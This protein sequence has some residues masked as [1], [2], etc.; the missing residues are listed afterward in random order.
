MAE[1]SIRLMKRGDAPRKKPYTPSSLKTRRVAPAT[2]LYLAGAPSVDFWLSCI[3]VLTTSCG[4]VSNVAKPPPK[5]PLAKLTRR[6]K[7]CCVK[8]CCE[9]RIWSE[10]DRSVPEVC[11][12]LDWW[13]G[14]DDD[15]RCDDAVLLMDDGGSE[16]AGGVAGIM[17]LLET[18][19]DR[20]SFR[21]T[22]RPRN[23]FV[24]K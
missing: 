20:V 23:C 2:V 15:G 4:C 16:G 5:A 17:A 1:P 9:L 8:P 14:D 3:R 13:V 24:R 6:V 10:V 22:A 21:P 11:A 18:I 12:E 7:P 19:V